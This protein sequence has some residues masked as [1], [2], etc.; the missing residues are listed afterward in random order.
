[1]GDIG[2]SGEDL[3]DLVTTITTLFRKG[4]DADRLLRRI[5][6]PTERAP[7]VDFDHIQAWNTIFAD[8][9]AGVIDAPYR[10]LLTAAL[11]VF[12]HHPTLRRLDAKA[13]KP[14][15]HRVLVVGASPEGTERIRSDRELKQILASQEHGHIAVSVCPAATVVDLRAVAVSRPHVLH[16]ACHGDGTDLVFEDGFGDRRAVAATQVVSLLAT[17]RQRLGVALSGVVLNSCHSEKIAELFRPVAEVVIAHR[18]ALDDEC[19]IVFAGELYRALRLAPSLADA[20]HIAAEHVS[21]GEPLCAST[22][23]DLVV[24]L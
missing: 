10:R 16:L 8:L 24:L 5:G 14:E 18:G 21:V 7:N 13:S 1:M 15:V 6:Y 2:L 22:K 9:A 4:R 3:D 20:A 11:R 19:A 12:P 23:N 17:Y